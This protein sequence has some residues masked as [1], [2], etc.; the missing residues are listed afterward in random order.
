MPSQL[1]WVAII[2]SGIGVGGALF[3][4]AISGL[5]TYR[6]TKR[7]TE[8]QINQVTKQ[9]ESQEA[10]ARRDRIIQ[11]RKAYLDPVRETFS[12]LV[13]KHR[14]ITSAITTAELPLI[15]QLAVDHPVRE[16]LFLEITTGMTELSQYV[17]PM[18]DASVLISDAKLASLVYAVW[19]DLFNLTQPV[20]TITNFEEVISHIT[21]SLTDLPALQ[22][23]I[24][25]VNQ[26]IE[27]LLSGAELSR[28]ENLP[29]P[30][31]PTAPSPVPQNLA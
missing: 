9:I 26:R 5:V 1:V 6:V 16:K 30:P 14:S 18:L 20:E 11:A 8:A 25:E 21:E 10:E 15:K 17:S 13:G 3:G 4:A 7:Q 24:L 22:I 29:L 19:T 31:A 23:K 12:A 2:S 27:E 28:N